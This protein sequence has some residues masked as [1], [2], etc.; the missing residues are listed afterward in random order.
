MAARTD[1]LGEASGYQHIRDVAEGRTD[2]AFQARWETDG[3]RLT[4][5]FN[6]AA[7][8]RVYTGY[9]PGRNPDDRVP[10]IV[11][12]RRGKNATFEVTHRIENR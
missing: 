4:L 5:R 10:L 3:A 9:G 8:T 2:G 11:V 12:R 1:A 7:G 6:S